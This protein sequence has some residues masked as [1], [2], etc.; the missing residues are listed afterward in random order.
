M[1]FLVFPSRIGNKKYGNKLFP[2]MPLRFHTSD[3]LPTA[4]ADGI[5]IIR[6][7]NMRHFYMISQSGAKYKLSSLS[8]YTFGQ[9]PYPPSKKG[10]RH[11]PA[12]Y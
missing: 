12:A 1:V 2:Y 10:F 4:D 3:F 6:A 7:N 8:F 11:M 9:T 5:L